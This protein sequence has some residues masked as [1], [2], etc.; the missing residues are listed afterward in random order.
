MP[1]SH[2]IFLPMILS[3][4]P[5]TNPYAF[6]Q[7]ASKAPSSVRFNQAAAQPSE[8]ERPTL[9]RGPRSRS[10]AKAKREKVNYWLPPDKR[11]RNCGPESPTNDLVVAIRS[12]DEPITAERWSKLAS[13][14]SSA[15]RR[16]NV[17]ALQALIKNLNKDTKDAVQ[18][19]YRL[20]T[21]AQKG[22]QHEDV[23]HWLW[24]LEAED[25]DTKV[26]RLVSTTRHKPI[27]V[28]MAILRTDEHIVKG[29]TLITLYDY[30]AQT[31]IQQGPNATRARKEEADSG[32]NLDTLDNFTNMTPYHWNLL[33]SRLV[34]HCL[35]T[36]PSSLPMIANLVVAYMRVMRDSSTLKRS[37]HTTGYAIRCSVFNDALVNFRRTAPAASLA[38]Q[39]YNWK[40]QKILLGYSAGLTR[41]YIISKV[42]YRA[43]RL[44]LMGLQKSP[45]EK[46]T[47]SRHTK[48]WPPY[49]RQLDG[50]DEA[51]QKEAYYSR[52]VKAGILKQSEGYSHD[53]TD[54]AID[55]LGG[56][57]PDQSISIQTRA[58]G[59][60]LWQNKHKSDSIFSL[61][62]AKVKATRNSFEAWE[63]FNRSP[64]RDLKPDYQVYAE[65]FEKLYAVEA[66]QES[67]FLPGDGKETSA[68]YLR[69]LTEFEQER[70]SPCKP[71]ELYEKM[72]KSGQRPVHKCLH[73]L[74]RNAPSVEKARQYLYDSTLPSRAVYNMTVRSVPVNRLLA[75]IPIGTFDAYISFLCRQ[76][77]RRRLPANRNK[78][79][80]PAVQVR[81]SFIDRAIRLV[82]SRSGPRRDLDS[83][84][85]HTLMSALS[86]DHLVLRPNLSRTEDDVVA[87]EAMMGLYMA[88][89]RSL[90]VHPIPF[91]GLCRCVLKVLRHNLP[92]LHTQDDGQYHNVHTAQLHRDVRRLTHAAY[93]ILKPDFE[94]LITPVQAPTD[95]RLTTAEAADALPPLYHELSASHI[96]SYLEVIAKIG[97]ADEG[98]RVMDWVLMTCDPARNS[99]RAN[100]AAIFAKARDPAHKQW[101]MMREATVCFRAMAEAF[102][103]DRAVMARMQAR[104][105][106]L[107]STVGAWA[108]PEEE[109]VEVYNKWQAGIQVPPEN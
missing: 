87:L 39:S 49:I 92:T 64:A 25:T 59:F 73:V 70:V 51:R 35:R 17:F 80:R 109:D 106:E 9:L 99:E 48:T 12:R 72:I 52:V 107:S 26:E 91:N 44:V 98:V 37:G 75:S 58:Q 71:D 32:L 50:T 74:I 10:T 89:R 97:D 104:F 66:D 24:I 4:R 41:P 102:H 40:A 83:A 15:S 68:P 31:Y 21:F 22:I 82:C 63:M 42:G 86:Y 16:N 46:L 45:D 56:A 76:Q 101:R 5:V 95:A 23:L 7:V 93:D 54:F 105:E 38:N 28:L 43:I 65:M 62:A 2:N 11:Q 57:S 6:S 90:D 88:Y 29:S 19:Q 96:R 81:H 53:V 100:A 13:Y 60:L 108:W 27:F 18:W 34:H 8:L 55:R 77:G 103:L 36:F 33:M 1:P 61:W 79:L 69:N 3:G 94:A 85:W 14:T 67:S 84:P 30:I 20:S 47:A 78:Q